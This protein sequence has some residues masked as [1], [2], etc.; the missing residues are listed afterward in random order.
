MKV[1]TLNMVDDLCL[2]A[3]VAKELCKNWH[4]TGDVHTCMLSNPFRLLHSAPHV[5]AYALAL[6]A[7]LRNF[8]ACLCTGVPAGGPSEPL[9]D[10]GSEGA[11][12][13]T[14]QPLTPQEEEVAYDNL[15]LGLGV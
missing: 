2:A 9:V 3:L 15:V 8:G 14:A 10:D 5:A 7:V 12:P 6:V 1:S 13:S 4:M 11:G